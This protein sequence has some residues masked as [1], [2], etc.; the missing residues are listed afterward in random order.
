MVKTRIVPTC[1]QQLRNLTQVIGSEKVRTAVF[2]TEV[3]PIGEGLF[4]N[5]SIQA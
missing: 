5:K 3:N 1:R 2:G 4:S